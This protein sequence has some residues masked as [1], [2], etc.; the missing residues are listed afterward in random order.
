MIVPSIDVMSGRA[1]QLRRG[2]E[3]VLDGGDPLE[4]L[5]EFAVVGE[6]AVVDLD[7]ALGRGSNAVL[8]REMVRRAPC[9][10]GGGIRDVETALGW[11]DAGAAKVVIGS[12]ASPELCAALPRERVV[13]ALDARHGEVV[14]DGW[15]TATG[16]S[17]AEALE[18]LAPCV[19]G[20]LLTQVEHEG[21]LGGFALDTARAAAA[22]AP[23]C[24]ITAAG[25]ITT[26]EEITALDRVGIDAQVGMALYT[27]KLELGDAF[28]APLARAP[29][30]GLWPTVVC[31]DRGAALGLVW[32][33]RD[34]LL[35]AVRERRGVYFSRSRDAIW[36]KGE[37]SGNTQQLVRAELDCDRDAIRFVV[38]QRGAGF[39]HRG[40]R[41]CW[42]EPFDLGRL[43]RVLRERAADA[44]AAS[45]TARLL[46]EPALLGAKLVE[47]AGEL[48]RAS[49]RAEAVH[50]AADLLYFTLT[51]L[52]GAEGTFPEV[53]A[54]LE[55]RH[56]RVTR[57]P[58]AARA[59]GQ[60]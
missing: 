14:V 50:E 23:D 40:S 59:A 15:R 35:Q 16:H 42:G 17:V 39:C 3:F 49:S 58:M 22:A 44:D 45:G 57:R 36:I 12:A 27:R 56:R 55:R 2:E 21:T 18:P 54:E 37:T 13:V 47:E 30:D 29:V 31:D 24:R 20:F 51:A 48:A 11:L 53:L 4:R 32:S 7:A 26:A 46:R 34:S 25:G 43:E 41:S 60:S 8:L 9:R 1:V 52:V 10:V 6:V 38:R 19:G 5:E 28:A 33:S